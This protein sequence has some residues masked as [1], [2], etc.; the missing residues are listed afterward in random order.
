MS[1]PLLQ[2]RG[3]VKRYAGLVATDHLDLDIDANEVHAIIGPNGAG[4]T[5]LIHQISGG[6][7][8]NEGVIRFDGRD[9]TRIPMHER[10]K[11]GLA[12]TYQITNIF[13]S[14]S[15]LDNLALAVQAR[16]GSSMRFWRKAVAEADIFEEARALADKV[17][18]G[19]H[20][21]T[22][23]CNLAHGE[24]RQLEVGLGLATRP[25]LLLLDEPMAGM[26]PQE[27]AQLIPLLE[28]LRSELAVLLV[29]HDM[30]AV[31]QMADRISVLVAGR[32]IATGSVDEIRNNAEVK[33]AYLGEEE[34]A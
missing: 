4:K 21:G 2:L 11:M 29:E 32:I 30:E 34:L 25:K 3:L 5:T 33:K 6:L 9:V 12:R 31:F 28:G 20:A 17:G 13:K 15:V 26:G 19:T 16:R 10:V 18:L 23:A 8:P 1:A 24:Q 27:S 7:A 22:L 14:Y